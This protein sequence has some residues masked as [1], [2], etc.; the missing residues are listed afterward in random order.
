MK[1]IALAL[2]A[3]VAATGTAHAEPFQG[4]YVGV[5]LIRDAFEVKADNIDLGGGALSVDGISGNG[6]GGGLYAGYDYSIGSMFIGVEANANLTSASVSASLTGLGN[7]RISTRESYGVSARVG[8]K[9]SD[10][11]GL[12]ARLGWQNTKFKARLS[13]GVDTV[14]FKDTQ[15]AFVYGAGLET[16]VAANTSV[17]VEYTIEDF[18][19]AGLGVNGLSVDNNKLALGLS[20]RF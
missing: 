15:D 18:G 12:Y 19:S 20:Y 3:S 7:A 1:K 6:V 16:S 5:S 14:T 2:I 13:D 4:P 10:T 11:T 17:R 8:G 9:L